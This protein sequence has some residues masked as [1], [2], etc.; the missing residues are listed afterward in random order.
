MQGPLFISV[1][2]PDQLREFLDANPEVDP[3]CAFVDSSPTFDAY[4]SAGFTNLLGE[5]ELSEPPDFKPP[6]MMS[7]GKWMS[8]FGKV[9]KVSPQ[10]QKF[11]EFPQGVR[12]LGGTYVIDDS[13]ILFSHQDLVPGATPDLADVFA[14]GGIKGVPV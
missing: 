12:V 11:G 10:P 1:G 5:K 2:K 8:Y 13:S 6:K 9:M 7:F 4:R 14:A 3:E